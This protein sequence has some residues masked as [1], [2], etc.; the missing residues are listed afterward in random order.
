[1]DHLKKSQGTITN[2]S[3][4]CVLPSFMSVHQLV[5]PI[6]RLMQLWHTASPEAI[7]QLQFTMDSQDY[8]AIMTIN[9]LALCVR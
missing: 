5:G 6:R 4:T 8:A 7:R 1:M 9:L 2:I 3:S